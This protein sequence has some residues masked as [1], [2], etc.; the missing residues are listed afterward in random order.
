MDWLVCASRYTVRVLTSTL[1]KCN[2][3]EASQ[4]LIKLFA[5]FPDG[6]WQRHDFIFDACLLLHI[7]LGIGGRPKLFEFV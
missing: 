2:V 5:G 1:C 3:P 6:Y 7:F 4:L